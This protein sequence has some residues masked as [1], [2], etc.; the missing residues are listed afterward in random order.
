MATKTE[1]ADRLEQAAFVLTRDG[2][3][4]AAKSSTKC[5]VC[6]GSCT[7]FTHP[8]LDGSARQCG[9]CAKVTLVHVRLSADE[10]ALNA[11]IAGME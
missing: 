5:K 8:W 6:K 1:N 9:N 10:K 2:V 4:W 3:E 11:L 7:V